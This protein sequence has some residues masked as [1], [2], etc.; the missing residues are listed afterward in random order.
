VTGTEPTEVG[1]WDDE[2]ESTSVALFSGD[3]GRLPFDQR[4]CL[5]RLLKERYVSRETHPDLWDVL[6]DNED[7][8]S[9]R[10]NDLFLT[11]H[12]DRESEVAYKRQAIRDDDVKR[13]PT[14]LH[15]TSYNREETILL[16]H[17]RE[18]LQRE[19]AAGADVVLVD[20][21]EL[22]DRVAEFRLADATDIVAET[23][24]ATNAVDALKKSGVLHPSGEADRFK[25]SPVLDS[26]MPLPR[27]K[28]LLEW[29]RSNPDEPNDG[30][31]DDAQDADLIEGELT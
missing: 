24:R 31:S 21:E 15:D 1:D 28:E 23:K 12:V 29:L 3:A 13:F 11:L 16:V 22:I 5:I 27:L 2:Q 18:R 26:L 19:R 9:S 4:R 10:L 7:A 20:L 8:L 17:L 6:I 14:L 30:P 25:V